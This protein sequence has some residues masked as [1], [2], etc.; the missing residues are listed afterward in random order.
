MESTNKIC[1]S[2]HEEHKI[3]YMIE[4]QAERFC[5]DCY[6][7]Y[8]D[9]YKHENPSMLGVLERFMLI[10]DLAETAGQPCSVCDSCERTY[11]LDWVITCGGTC[12]FC[13]DNHTNKSVDELYQELIERMG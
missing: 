6:D 9:H 2:C 3:L 13:G 7:E 12:P 11:P 1:E 8:I 5:K 4:G 10:A